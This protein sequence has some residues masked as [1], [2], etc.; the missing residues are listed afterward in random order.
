MK[1]NVMLTIETTSHSLCNSQNFALTMVTLVVFVTLG[2][3]DAL[4]ILR[5]LFIKEVDRVC[6][7]MRLKITGLGLL[8]MMIILKGYLWTLQPNINLRDLT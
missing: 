8:Q 6:G 3:L 2:S 5:H 4:S 7:S 1:L